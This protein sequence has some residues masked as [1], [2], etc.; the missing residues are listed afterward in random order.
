MK[1]SEAREELKPHLKDYVERITSKS[2]G[3]D[4]YVCPLCGS[5]KGSKATGAFSIT[6]D[7]LN[8][9]CFSCGEGGDIFDLIG[10]VEHIEDHNA[11]LWRAAALF[12]VNLEAE[13][14]VL[15][16]PKTTP[17]KEEANEP[18]YTE[19]FLKA[20]QDLGKT[21]YHRGISMD[22]LNRFRIGYVEQWRHPNA[23]EYVQPSPRL[24]IPTSRHSYL[25]RD[26]RENV[27]EAQKPYTKSK[28]GKIHLFNAD[29]LSTAKK[30]I[31]IVEGELDALSLIDV[32]G[33]AI[34]LGTTTKVDSFLALLGRKKPTQLL[35]LALDND[36]AGKEAS[37][38][39]AKG[40]EA[41]KIPYSIQNPCG[42]FKDCNEALQNNRDALREAVE[43]AENIGKE[44][45]K[46][47]REE[48]LH[49]A[50]I[51][52][53]KDFLDGIA[54]NANAPRYPTGFVN[55][56]RALDGGLYSGLITIGAESSTGKTTLALQI[57]DFVAKSGTDVLI[58][59]L[60]MSRYELIARSLSRLTLTQSLKSG[61]GKKLAKTVM[62]I[63]DGRRHIGYTE[64]EKENL[65]QAV[66]AYSK[67]ANHIYIS[68]GIGDIGV[69]EIRETVKKH[70]SYTGN[71]PLIIVDYL[72]ILAPADVRGTDKANTDKAVLE[73]KRLSRDVKTPVIAI[74][75]YNRSSYKGEGSM[76][77]FRESS[78]IEYTSDICLGLQFQGKGA[79]G[80]DVD[81]AKQKTPREMELV[82]MKNRNGE[83]G[84]RLRFD[85]YPQFNVFKD[86]I[87]E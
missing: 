87:T 28:V 19:F 80:F 14:P 1:K 33:E 38:K 4:M 69:D 27:P 45:E 22:T 59:S 9:K 41:L 37:D 52:Y 74:S 6:K 7:G 51:H 20:N 18:D 64:A 60:E 16:V 11:Q 62:D 79:D 30:P 85:Y 17:T 35:L 44:A 86:I 21:T 53:L 67:F 12:N 23:P 32:G 48:Y 72:Q 61:N 71:H 82:I 5:G 78:S 56:D 39:L 40:L 75:A 83:T 58:F 15:H 73:L 57:G 34:A 76:A 77:S 55:L 63:L 10:Q 66:S 47:S 46:L 29:A 25:A 26:T 65:N 36:A 24:I 50:T 2:K 54:E 8:W 49:T 68:E 70:I 3:R 84:K 13:T 42:T 43:E 81:S 31:F